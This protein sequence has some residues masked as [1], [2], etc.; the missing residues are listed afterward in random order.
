[1]IWKNFLSVFIGALLLITLA[2]CSGMPSEA[3][4][5]QAGPF[6]LVEG[7]RADNSLK[8]TDNVPQPYIALYKS[9]DG[10]SVRLGVLVYPSAEEAKKALQNVEDRNRKEN[11]RIVTVSKAG[12]KLVTS[13]KDMDGAIEQVSVIWVH[14]NWFC[15]ADSWGGSHRPDAPLQLA[16]SLPYK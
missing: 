4:P 8:K 11:E 2:G 10:A 16:N 5:K 1:M 9:S 13:H 6:T 7:P 3:F 15:I 14:N 12:D